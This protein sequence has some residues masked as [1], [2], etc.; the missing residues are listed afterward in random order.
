MKSDPAGQRPAI[1]LDSYSSYRE[2]HRRVVKG[3][4]ENLQKFFKKVK[5]SG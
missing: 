5:L 1:V 3:R 4:R 2:A